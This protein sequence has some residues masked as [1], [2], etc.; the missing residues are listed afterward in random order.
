MSDITKNIIKNFITVGA[1]DGIWI[2]F[3]LPK[4]K[5][6]AEK[7]QHS[8]CEPDFK[9]VIPMYIALGY[10]LEKANSA[11]EA[12]LFGLFINVY[13]TSMML[14]LYK[15]YNLQAASVDIIWGGFLMAISYKFLSLIHM[16]T[17]SLQTTPPQT[18]I[19]SP[20]DNNVPVDCVGSFVDTLKCD[21]KTGFLTK[22]YTVISADKNGGKKCLYSQGDIAQGTTPCAD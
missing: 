14:T 19:G 2:Y 22:R 21:T 7:I 17:S 9:Y 5:K 10:F 11:T 18:I 12:F 20:V 3:M 4:Y 13:Y 8:K 6:L 15:N 1:I 16:K